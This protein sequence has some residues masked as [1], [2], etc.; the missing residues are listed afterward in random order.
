MKK[1]LS[2]ILVWLA[3]TAIVFS[4]SLA[5]A[6]EVCI[7]GTIDSVES[8]QTITVLTE[9]GDKYTVHYPDGNFSSDEENGDVGKY[10]SVKGVEQED[11]S[12]LANWVK[13]VCDCEGQEGC[14]CE[15]EC[16]CVGQEEC[17]CEKECECEDP[18]ECECEQEC[19]CEGQ[20]GCECDG[21]I[22]D[23]AYCSGWKEK[24]HPVISYL[25]TQYDK[26]YSELLKQFCSGHG[27]GQIWLAL[28]TEKALDF[29]VTYD[30]LLARRFKGEGW[31]VIW[32]SL[33]SQ[34]KTKGAEHTPP[35]QMKKNGNLPPG[36]LKKN[37]NPPPGQ[38]KKNPDLYQDPDPDPEDENQAKFNNKWNKG[39]KPKKHK[40]IKDSIKNCTEPSDC[41]GLSCNNIEKYAQIILNNQ[42]N[43]QRPVLTHA[44][45]CVA[46]N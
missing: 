34:D 25:A 11:G 21:N 7:K 5:K 15:E 24:S 3:F 38:L 8:A 12:I 35:G 16:E 17:E 9:E 27:I 30:E 42:C 31:G 20:E 10:V 22:K 39:K 44:G 4:P 45:G 32:K 23:G 1:L 40:Q 18:E 43:I 28:Q 36:Q 2:I 13:F 37:G 26:T 6:E 41:G 46:T 14:E 33:D 19:E 29:E